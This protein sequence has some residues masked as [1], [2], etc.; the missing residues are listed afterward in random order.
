MCVYEYMV[1]SFLESNARRRHAYCCI[2][3]LIQL[4]QKLHHTDIMRR[5][6]PLRKSM[7][8]ALSVA[9]GNG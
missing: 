5:H 7:I 6:I 1:V 4:V 3:E 2:P 8:L 9:V